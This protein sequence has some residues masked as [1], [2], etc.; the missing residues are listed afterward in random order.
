MSGEP[1]Q[2]G[3][4][5]NQGVTES[6][7][8]LASSSSR[9]TDPALA[10][11]RASS[12]LGHERPESYDA[13]SQS[14]AGLDVPVSSFEN[15]FAG[16]GGTDMSNLEANDD[17]NTLTAA[18]VAALVQTR[19]GPPP[20]SSASTLANLD[21]FQLEAELDALVRDDDGANVE[22]DANAGNEVTT[23]SGRRSRPTP[24]ALSYS[25][26]SNSASV[27]AA[28]LSD[29]SGANRKP[30]RIRWT[31][32]EDEILINLIKEEPPLTWTQMGE[33]MGRPGA[34]CAMRWYNFI[35]QQVGE[36][37]AFEL[38]MKMRGAPGGSRGRETR[39][40]EYIDEDTPGRE[41]TAEREVEIAPRQT[42]PVTLREPMQPSAQMQ[43]GSS[44][45][46]RA[47]SSDSVPREPSG[48]EDAAIQIMRG[49][50]TTGEVLDIATIPDDQLPPRLPPDPSKPGHPFPRVGALHC[51]SGPNFLPDQA[52][53]RDPPIPFP[54]NT[55]IRGR[56]THSADS[57]QAVIEQAEPF[58]KQKKVHTCPAVN[59]GA[60]FK[61]SEHLK[62][63]YK[64]V[65]RGEKP[66]PCKIENCGKSFSRKDNLQQHQAMVHG[67]RA[68]YTYSDGTVS[69]NP[70]DGDEDPVSITYEEVDITKTA[71]GAARHA[72][73]EARAQR[74]N[75]KKKATN[76]AGSRRS[77]SDSNNHEQES[78]DQDDVDADERLDRNR[79]SR[80]P[81]DQ[82]SSGPAPFALPTP[83]SV[84]TSRKSLARPPST[85]QGLMSS[86]SAANQSL[87]IGPSLHSF[88]GAS[89]GEYARRSISAESNERG[90]IANGK[91]S[92]EGSE[93]GGGGESTNGV[94]KRLR[95]TGDP[96]SNDL[97]PALKVLADA[98][99]T[100]ASSMSGAGTSS[101]A[102][103]SR[104]LSPLV[105]HALEQRLVQ[106]QSRDLPVLAPSPFA[107]QGAVLKPT[108]RPF[109]GTDLSERV[110]RPFEG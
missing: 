35:R 68:I 20:N 74:Q 51:N 17:E 22:S 79:A 42:A 31:A 77:R 56:R 5:V 6:G 43:V 93:G 46:A 1:R 80:E 67:V 19:D 84:A 71:R 8:H 36:A 89:R 82:A 9:L 78:E 102:P 66:F 61:R 65:H 98:T 59:C 44:R 94:D 58:A 32:Q 10:P 106:S 38:S 16:T 92:R 86:S 75:A 87:S 23:R 107:I 76:P 105:Q 104:G 85:V 97:D 15:V 11:L 52:L 96:L 101:I 37:E 110:A 100:A 91:R 54:K 39:A 2:G 28:S 81:V 40:E 25:R 95:L 57:L 103:N 33:R 45:A 48:Q 12:A 21:S 63:H 50:P 3:L 41:S 4:A 69:V 49:Y 34:G 55:V 90:G 73:Q 47:T 14:L 18:L 29:Q 83:P 109:A 99:A 24:A 62:R 88:N 60:A 27:P 108:A 7:H 70:P 26:G 30:T 13:P 53:V 72:R 64:S